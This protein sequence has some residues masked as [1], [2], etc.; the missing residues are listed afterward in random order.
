MKIIK[1]LLFF[2]SLIYLSGFTASAQQ[3]PI[4]MQNRREL[5]IDDAII[6]SL[7]NVEDRL[8][9]PT[10][11]GVALKFDKPWEG[12]FCTYVS[13]VNNGKKFQL[14]YRGVGRDGNVTDMVTCYAESTDGKTWTKPNL[15]LFKIN[16]SSDNNVVHTSNRRQQTTHNFAVMYDNRPG[17]PDA[18]KYKAVGG[19]YS[20]QK[21][22]RGLYRFVSPDGI[23]W[24]RFKDTTALFGDGY[25]MDSQNVPAWVP[26]EQ[27][28]A[29]Y[30]RKWTD[31]KPSDKKLLKDMSTI[32]RSTSKD[33]IHWTEPIAM[34]FGNTPME[35]LYTNATQSYFRAPQIMVSMPFRF[36]P[37][38][39]ILTDDEMKKNGIA[40]SMW[41]GVSDAVLMTSRGGNKYDRKFMESFA[42]PGLDE[43]NWAARSSIPSLGI[44]PTGDAEMSFFL[45]RA[46]STKDCYLERMVLRTDGFASLHARYQQGFAVTKPMLLKGNKLDINYSTSSIGYVKVV[47]LTPDGKEVPG[48]GEAD[49]QKIAGDKISYNVTWK[50]GKKISDITTPVRIKFILRDADLYSFGI[51]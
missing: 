19:V 46:Y 15:G 1:F 23:H 50:S 12:N 30:L 34:T 44:I 24:Q 7:H 37:D 31:D 22:K 27:C 26:A 35:N 2:G 16:G 9:T 33:F 10:S 18:E 29:I 32:A 8:C 21:I 36:S 38:S 48:F 49:A 6:D 14:Y 17:V 11:G 13:V 4:L 43:R 47:L 51:F 5:F 28:Y 39:R 42:R 3:K 40:K 41:Q 20:T 45:T 25:G